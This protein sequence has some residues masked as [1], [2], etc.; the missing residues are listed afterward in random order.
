[1]NACIHFLRTT[2]SIRFSSMDPKGSFKLQLGTVTE[3]GEDG[4]PGGT[5]ANADTEYQAMV[6][7]LGSSAFDGADEI[8]VFIGV[9]GVLDDVAAD[10]VVTRHRVV[11]STAGDQCEGVLLRQQK[12]TAATGGQVWKEINGGAVPMPPN[13]GLKPEDASKIIDWVLSLK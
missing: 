13:P 4:L 8:E 12:G 10:D 1:M 7:T 5:D 6:L 11:A 2:G 3:L 9:G